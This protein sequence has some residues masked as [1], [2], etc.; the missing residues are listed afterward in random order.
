MYIKT[1]PRDPPRSSAERYLAQAT[2]QYRGDNTIIS[3]ATGGSLTAEEYVN[4]FF[5]GEY[6]YSNRW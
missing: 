6:K 3:T 5:G 1:K 4:G 2:T